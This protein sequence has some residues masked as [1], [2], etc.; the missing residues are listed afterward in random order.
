[1]TDVGLLAAALNNRRHLWLARFTRELEI[2]QR[3]QLASLPE[4]LP[5]TDD[6]ELVG[7]MLP[8]REV[9]GDCYD[10]FEL[11]DA[12]IGIVVADVSGKGVPAALFMAI[13][14]TLLRA[15]AQRS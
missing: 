14:R 8:A 4:A 9:G 10:F 1:M 11:D 7:R 15:V 6:L 3:V 2:A 13:A 12:R 5:A